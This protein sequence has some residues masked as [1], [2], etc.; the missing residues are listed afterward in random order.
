MHT[1]TVGKKAKEAMH[2]EKKRLRLHPS[3]TPR[4]VERILSSFVA[5]E[6]KSDRQTPP[7]CATLAPC[8]HK[9]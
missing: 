1:D 4:P 5:L 3:S 8:T 2:A 6:D 9:Q 7:R